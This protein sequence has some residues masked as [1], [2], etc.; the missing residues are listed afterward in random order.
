MRELEDAL[1]SSH[2]AWSNET[3]PLLREDLL[4]IKNPL[5]RDAG[6]DKHKDAEEEDVVDAVGSL[7][8]S[9]FLHGWPRY[10]ISGR[11][12]SHTGRASFFGQTANAWVSFVLCLPSIIN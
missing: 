8:V 3:H 2:S 12:I 11:S 5:E 9:F 7:Y 6:Q 10:L 1:A 4:R